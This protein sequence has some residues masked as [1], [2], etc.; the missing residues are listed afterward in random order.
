M[1]MT[2]VN[3]N[4]MWASP[5]AYSRSPEIRKRIAAHSPD[6]V[7]LT[8]THTEMLSPS[9]GHIICSQADAGYGIRENM[10]KVMLWSRQPWERVDDL[11]DDA[12]PPGRYVSGVTQ[13]PIGEVTVMGICIPWHGSRTRK[14]RGAER[15]KVWED[16]TIYLKCLIEL[17]DRMPDMPMIVVGDFNQSIG[18][19]RYAPPLYMR[20]AVQDATPRHMTIATS[21]LGYDGR[22]TIDHT[23]LS[24]DLAAES[25][26]VIS[27]KHGDV[28]LSD[29]FGTAATL[30]IRGISS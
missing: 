2:L 4:V 19:K 11:G 28:E 10:R 9:G 7:C 20:A 25:L 23:A 26:S 14:E 1:K 5:R 8:E 24:N 21:A 15:K 30:S 22:R 18:Q 13:T 29:H 27:N 16:H 6:V 17:I 3:W 12:M